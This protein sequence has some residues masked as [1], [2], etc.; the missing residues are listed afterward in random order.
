MLRPHGVMSPELKPNLRTILPGLLNKCF[1]RKHGP[2][3]HYGQ[4]KI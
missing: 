2:D 4:A 1:N 3:T